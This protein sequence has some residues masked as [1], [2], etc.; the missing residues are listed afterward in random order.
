MTSTRSIRPQLRAAA[1]TRFL[2]AVLVGLMLAP[3]A[4]WATP[5]GGNVVAGDASIRTDGDHTTIRA[6]NRTIIEW[7]N[8]DIGVDESVRF[9]QPSRRSR[10]LNRVVGPNATY[11]EGQLRA[12]GTVYILNQLGIF[13]ADSA[14]VEVAHLVAAAGHLS[15]ADFLNGIDRFTELGGAVENLGKVRGGSVTLLGRSVSNHGSIHAPNGRIWMLAGD[16]VIV[17]EHGSPIILKIGTPSEEQLAS[18]AVENT[19]TLNAG[20]RGSVRMAAGDLLSLAVRNSGLIRGREISIAGG[21]NSRVQVG[22]TLDAS[23]TL[24]GPNRDGGTIDIRGDA[25]FVDDATLDASGRRGGGTIHIGGNVAGAL[26]PG[27]T[28]R[29][30]QITYISDDSIVRADALKTGD[31]GEIVA[32]SDG[33]TLVRGQLSARG[34]DRRGNGGFVETSGKKYLSANIVPDLGA[35]NGAGGTWL[36]DPANI[37]IVAV[38]TVGDPGDLTHFVEDLATAVLTST[39]PAILPEIETSQIEADTLE[40]ALGQGFN[41]TISTQLVDDSPGTQEGNIVFSDALDFDS[42]NTII[43]GT[44]ATLTLLA[45]NR[46]V[47]E[48]GTGIDD[49][50]SPNLALSLF[51][52]AGDSGQHQLDSSSFGMGPETGI[53]T[54]SGAFESIELKEALTVGGVIDLGGEDIIAE[55]QLT[56]AA[57]NINA[58]HAVS[59][60]R[61]ATTGG[62]ILIR[63]EAGN[64]DIIGVAGLADDVT[65]EGGNLGI[66]AVGGS[67]QLSGDVD[68]R[69]DPTDPTATAGGALSFASIPVPVE[70]QA[71][72]DG[73][74]IT[75]SKIDAGDAI[76]A[77]AGLAVDAGGNLDVE[78]D[79]TTHNSS[80]SFRVT[81]NEELVDILDEDGNTISDVPLILGDQTLTLRGD[82]VTNGGLI[83]VESTQAV[84]VSPSVLDISV[85]VDIQGD[86]NA[87]DTVDTTNHGSIQVSTSGHVDV[88]NGVVFSGDNVQVSAGLDGTGDLNFLGTATFNARSAAAEAGDGYS[89]DL[90]DPATTE[91]ADQQ[92]RLDSQITGLG[93]VTMQG[94]TN[95]DLDTVLILQDGDFATSN[96]PTLDF[97]ASVEP[98]LE[99]NSRDRTIHVEAN[100]LDP[101][102]PETD[103][104]LFMLGAGGTRGAPFVLDQELNF[105]RVDL[106]SAGDFTIDDQAGFA[107]RASGANTSELRIIAGLGGIIP[108]DIERQPEFMGVPGDLIID[109]G[110]VLSAGTILDVHG[111]ANGVGDLQ[112]GD[113][114]TL[115]ADD[116]RMRAGDGPGGSNFIIETDSSIT[117]PSITSIAGGPITNLTLDNASAN[118]LH[119]TYQQEA[120]I[121]VGD[122]IPVTDADSVV[123][124]TA[125]SDEGSIVLDDTTAGP[126][127]LTDQHVRLAAPSFD[128]SGLTA[129]IVTRSLDVGGITDLEVDDVLLNSFDWGT[130]DLT[131]RA[132]TGL[133]FS[134]VLSFSN[135]T[136][137]SADSVRLVASDGLGAQGTSSIDIDGATFTAVDT[138]L[139]PNEFIMEQDANLF[140]IDLP[141]TDQFGDGIGTDKPGTLGLR[142]VD[143]DL[144]LDSLHEGLVADRLLL[145]GRLVVIDNEDSNLDLSVIPDL[146]IRGD[147]IA[148]RAAS[149]NPGDT[150]TNWK[151]LFGANNTFFGYDIEEAGNE[152]GDLDLTALDPTDTATRAPDVFTVQQD[153]TILSSDLPDPALFSAGGPEVNDAILYRLVAEEVGSIDVDDETPVQG[154]SLELRLANYDQDDGVD[155]TVA[156]SSTNT[157]F[158]NGLDITVPESHVFQNDVSIDATGLVRIESGTLGLADGDL[159]FGGSGTSSIRATEIRLLA[160]SGSF[161]TLD[162]TADGIGLTGLA[163]ISVAGAGLDLTLDDDSE[164]YATALTITQDASLD[165]GALL[166][167][168]FTVIAPSKDPGLTDKLDVLSL[169][170]RRG[171][172]N[173]DI[174]NVTDTE[175]LLLN[176]GT[177]SVAL[178]DVETDV[179]HLNLHSSAGDLELGTLSTDHLT[180]LELRADYVE[181]HADGAG[182][183][184]VMD[185]DDV[186]V[187]GTGT[188]VPR[189][190]L[191]S[192]DLAFVTDA[193]NLLQAD[194]FGDDV[195]GL[196]Y[197]LRTATGDFTVD[198]AMA[199]QLS[200]FDLTLDNTT[201]PGGPRKITLDSSLD[202]AQ[203]F[204]GLHAKSDLVEIDTSEFATL[205][206]QAY[207]APVVLLRSAELLGLDILFGNTVTADAAGRDLQLSVGRRAQFAEGVG[208]LGGL[209]AAAAGNQLRDLSVFFLNDGELEFGSSTGD[210]FDVGEIADADADASDTGVFLQ[211][212]LRVH[213][214]DGTRFVQDDAIEPTLRT[215]SSDIATIYKRGTGTLQISA[216][217][218][219]FG[220]VDLGSN[221]T[222]ES[223]DTVESNGEKLT[224]LG[225]IDIDATGNVIVGDL[226][227]LNIEIDAHK[228]AVLKRTGGGVRDS[229]GNIHSDAGVDWIAN[230]FA[231]NTTDGMNEV[232]QLGRG[233]RLVIGT[234]G[235]PPS[236]GGVVIDAPLFAI[237]PNLGP[238]LSSELSYDIDGS[239]PDDGSLNIAPY[240]LDGRPRGPS[241]A[242][243]SDAIAEVSPLPD[244]DAPH[245]DNIVE[246]DEFSQ[247]GIRTRAATGREYAARA[248]NRGIYDDAS[249]AWRSDR[250]VALITA[251]RLDVPN[252]RE[253]EHLFAE[254]FGSD[255]SKAGEIRTAL[256]K[257]VADYQ[258]HTGV[259]RVLGFELRRYLKNRPST[260]FTAYQ[261][262]ESLDQLFSAHRRSGMVPGEYAPIQRIWIEA[263]T[264]D[265]IAPAELAEA[266]QPSRYVRGSDVLDVF[267][268]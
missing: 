146:E 90:I 218:V 132:G 66:T 139:A 261:V 171:N 206:T 63:A 100:S 128:F 136:T 71:A 68:L 131:L 213:T 162:A 116:I 141:A 169:E 220:W 119:V 79:V 72:G 135:N 195:L 41:I 105:D 89:P 190:V 154:T 103:L 123:H 52:R 264:P 120:P 211:G 67:I 268:E 194:Q 251:T 219:S 225:T 121:D 165:S 29:N 80:A 185:E 76:V 234:S 42:P 256:G 172:L 51:L 37:E 174:A 231:L 236:I 248:Q 153:A 224:A 20:N 192:Q 246:P 244:T 137:V 60:R 216:D 5:S 202:G 263:I 97:G 241:A 180:N 12:N 166:S 223:S 130:G 249:Q 148:L 129:P 46:I 93:G 257:A 118:D 107:D 18:Y 168:G 86:L 53:G 151:V 157:Y 74:D 88:Q 65:T 143:G 150:T 189:S 158:L 11:I 134:G 45:A 240:I 101:L 245:G 15:N 140:S 152:D 54:T 239:D 176:S 186:R 215:P 184:L 198:L 16:E 214:I 73:G 69:S 33:A 247:V 183:R 92:L 163:E 209:T 56:A 156:L 85:N 147:E 13:I 39:N 110:I 14:V 197:E 179:G 77:P 188:S 38:P 35:R 173:V 23:N 112:I 61:L 26:D 230:T 8:F 125:I 149:S 265:G 98:S 203:R 160:G 114:V 83:V 81:D 58:R 222:L 55:Q 242:D 7:D 229:G 2:A 17:A 117:Y 260:Q 217:D 227:A 208:S 133:G 82:I 177:Y 30:S 62:D 40:A 25:I 10:V 31:G 155:R 111:G 250:Q 201:A 50:N 87:L 3:P 254:V 191:L 167:N 75:F 43:P 212:D 161:S 48:A 28:E 91:Y 145:A 182:S 138:T 104:Q 102:L 221:M 109:D 255:M 238:L 22:G 24:G 57:I 19:G 34:A 126:G 210:I 232:Q 226:T 159:I 49:T 196:D 78:H 6:D 164:N 84:D 235:T 253:A 178:D 4:L 259:R 199:E 233:Q 237:K 96:L 70:G 187:F 95:D 252:A 205:Q 115:Q 108:H 204:F 94:N 47:V 32:W 258:A 262:L 99:I 144:L 200:A 44:T 1:F 243:L 181:L 207:E 170:S 193:S 266:I 36:I 124:Y 59:T 9:I 27:S 228:L 175:A 21:E 142:S 113:G 127:L 122:L 267:G 64:A 106:R